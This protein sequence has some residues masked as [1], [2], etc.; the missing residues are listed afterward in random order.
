MRPLSELTALV[1][2]GG[3]FQGLGLVKALR[4]SPRIRVAMVDCE[5][6]NVT[7]H[8]VDAFRAVPRL[9]QEG[10]FL[11]AV[12]GFCA[13]EDV[14]LVF[15]A[16]ARELPVLARARPRFEARGVHVA[17][18][19]AEL[20]ALLADKRSLYA[21]LEGS[22]IASL[23]CVDPRAASL[24]LIGK[25][26]A[27]WGS[28]GVVVVR[29]EQERRSL[30]GVD[31]MVFQPYLERAGELSCDFAVG[32]D[33]SLSPVGVRR[34]IRSSGGFAVVGENVEDPAAEA[35]VGSLAERLRVRGARGLFNV[36]LLAEAGRLYVSDVNARFGTSAVHWCSV[37]P[38]P[39]LH[40]CAS[41]AP[42]LRLPPGGPERPWPRRRV[43]RHLE[44]TSWDADPALAA[45]EA[46]V[47]GVV[48]DLD[49]TL[50]DHK[51]WMRA[52]LERVLE[53]PPAPVAEPR[54][55]LLAA[56][57]LIE[58]GGAPRLIDLLAERFGWKTETRE[59]FLAAY[60]RAAPREAP[61]Y[62]DV[63]T[64][65]ESLRRRGYRL[66]LLTDNPPEGQRQKLAASELRSAWDAVVHTGE[67][68]VEKP[69]RRAFEAA[70]AALGLPLAALAMVGDNPY[71]DVVGSLQ[72]GFALAYWVRRSGSL[73]GFDAAWQ[74]LARPVGPHRVVAGIR[75]LLIHL[76]RA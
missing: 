9:E 76:A 75:P 27:G 10:A 59:A 41:V 1:V 19:D 39:A 55:L 14:G 6:E 61:L 38:N 49:D 2:S 46:R 65:I 13:E 53:S 52:K 56:S 66:A 73:H 47:R 24:P 33:G 58:E 8:F 54:A 16:T 50:L 22:G 42:A 71:R 15:P 70:G 30:G 31:G 69:D 60:R 32:F 29:S 7:R 12:L 35:L 57:W 21:F 67:L 37:G 63:L 68:G 44:E 40:V 64:T 74:D 5:P 43:I 3:L 17:V 18:P 62:P 20:V 26:A 11:D 34:R 36:Q 28:R 45:A 48:F 4:G 25:P 72:A 51:A 23:P